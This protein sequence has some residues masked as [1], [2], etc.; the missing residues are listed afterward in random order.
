MKTTRR[1]C[2]AT[3][4]TAATAITLIPCCVLSGATQE[5]V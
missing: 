3:S 5:K 4:A 1:Q 2:L